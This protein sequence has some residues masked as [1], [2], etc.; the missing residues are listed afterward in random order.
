MKIEIDEVDFDFITSIL[1]RAKVVFESLGRSH[2]VCAVNRDRYR[3]DAKMAHAR[4]TGRLLCASVGFTPERMWMLTR[5]M[6][7]EV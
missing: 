5:P 2:D 3:E 7:K 6:R 4:R 1:R